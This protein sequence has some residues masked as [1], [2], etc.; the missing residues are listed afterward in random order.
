MFI[1]VIR[2]QVKDAAGLRREWDRWNTELQ[3]G[4][5]GWLGA[6]AGTTPKGDFIAVVRFESEDAAQSNSDRSEQGKWW[7]A[8]SANL[9]GPATFKES[10]EIETTLAG[11][12]DDAGFVQVMTGR[13]TDAAKLRS[14][15]K[16]FE[17]FASQRPDLIGGTTA[18]HTDGTFT[19]TNYFKSEKEARE[20]ESKTM[21]E[22]M[23]KLFGDFMSSIADVEYLDISQPW[24]ASPR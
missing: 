2:G 22:D 23:Q 9:D 15:T 5:K 4:A 17:R 13:V 20:G 7:S 14:A 10:K 6:T 24:L 19:D 1:Q 8:F 16:G 18:Y 3:P 21:P 11:G 12:S